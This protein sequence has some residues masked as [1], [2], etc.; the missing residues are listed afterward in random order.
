MPDMEVS[1]KGKVF[2]VR[3]NHPRPLVQFPFE[4]SST[5]PSDLPEQLQITDPASRIFEGRP[6]VLLQGKGIVI[7][8]KLGVREHVLG[9]GE[10]A[11]DLDEGG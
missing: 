5:S 11:F 8:R 1:R 10:K 4:G 2:R 9:L 6:H 3:I 7:Q